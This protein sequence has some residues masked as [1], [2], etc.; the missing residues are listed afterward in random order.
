MSSSP[1]LCW[2]RCHHCCLCCGIGH[3]VALLLLSSAPCWGGHCHH[4]HAGLESSLSSALLGWVSSSSSPWHW[5]WGCVDII[6]ELACCHQVIRHRHLAVAL[7]MH[8]VS[9]PSSSCWDGDTVVVVVSVAALV[10]C[11]GGHG[12]Y[13]CHV[14]GRR[15]RVVDHGHGTHHCHCRQL[16]ACTCGVVWWWSMQEVMVGWWWFAS[17][18]WFELVVCRHWWW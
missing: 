1:S 3:G 14:N 4:S 15:G 11:A 6:L 17:W 18:W 12:G 16:C 2:G 8:I 9:S 13:H 5:L 10:V 7:A